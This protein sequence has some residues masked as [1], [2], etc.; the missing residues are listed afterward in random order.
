MSRQHIH[1][2]LHELASVMSTDGTQHGIG[3]PLIA[4][5]LTCAS[6]VADKDVIDLLQ[7]NDASASIKAMVDAGVARLPYPELVVEFD[8][9]GVM[10]IFCLLREEALSGEIFCHVGYMARSDGAGALEMT[11]ICITIENGGFFIKLPEKQM[12][13]HKEFYSVA[14]LI[15]VSVALLML[16]TKG[17]TKEVIECQKL[18]RTREKSGKVQIPR[19]TIVRIGTVYA[20]DGKGQSYGH[21]AK[22]PHL[23][24]GYTRNQHYGVNNEQTKIVF[25]PACIVNY[26]EGSDIQAPRKELRL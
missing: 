21:G 9:T 7:R 26:V 12:N 16:N 13:T 10:R 2:K 5:M 6:Y 15:A 8:L 19:H 11:P 20:R 18:N 3:N 17:I 1:T 23:R 14:A 4:K 24:S 25:I 22:R